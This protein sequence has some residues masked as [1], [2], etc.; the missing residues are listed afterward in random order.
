MRA[1]KELL[2]KL[3]GMDD[4]IDTLKADEESIPRLKQELEETVRDVRERVEKAKVESVE[5]AKRRKEQEV[6][7]EANGDKIAKY[8]TQMFQ[9]KSNR[10]YEALQHEIDALKEKSSQLEDE[11]LATL[12]RAEEVSKAIVAEEKDLTAETERAKREEAELDGRLK[13]LQEAIALKSSERDSLA[14]D[15]DPILLKRYDR[16]RRSKGGLAVTSVENGACGGCHR[17][18]PPH[19]MQNLKKD[20]KIITCEGCGRIIIWRWE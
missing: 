3:Q 2:L 6:E 7:L 9:V 18:I 8:Q 11:I 17:R 16:I 4:E 12:E 1:T 14:S 13:E 5:L 10:E 15:L 19:E 20:D